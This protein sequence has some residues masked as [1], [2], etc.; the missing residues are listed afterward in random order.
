MK[1]NEIAR[2]FAWWIPTNHPPLLEHEGIEDDP[3]G[4]RRGISSRKRNSSEVVEEL[5]IREFL[6]IPRTP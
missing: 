2:D 5:D 3:G 6:L 1:R 4:A